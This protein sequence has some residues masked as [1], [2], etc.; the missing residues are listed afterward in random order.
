MEISCG[1]CMT[2]NASLFRLSL[3]V[4]ETLITWNKESQS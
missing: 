3:V 1:Y 4:D 2:P